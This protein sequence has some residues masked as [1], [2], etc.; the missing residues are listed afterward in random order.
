MREGSSQVAPALASVLSGEGTTE[1]ESGRTFL[2]DQ[3]VKLSWRRQKHY[4]AQTLI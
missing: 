4:R 3:A 1:S 2:L